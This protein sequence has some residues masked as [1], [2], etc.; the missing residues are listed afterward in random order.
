MT[1]AKTATTRTGTRTTRRP[2]TTSAAT[3]PPAAKEQTM[4]INVTSFAEQAMEKSKQAA[5]DMA[6][7]GQGNVEAVMETSRIAARGMESMGSDA[8]AYA[9]ASFDRTAAHFRAMASFTSPA[10]FLKSQG[11]FVRASFDAMV[12]EASRSTE[13][14][15]KLAGELAQPLQNRVALAAEKIKIAA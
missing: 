3:L 6:A 15:L 12:A 10:D 9:R 5:E 7:F 4:T 13:A 8:A 14:S 11:D 2:R 1:E